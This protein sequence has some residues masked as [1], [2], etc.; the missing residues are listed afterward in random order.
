MAAAAAAPAARRPAPCAGGPP[1]PEHAACLRCTLNRPCLSC[2][3][4][5]RYV[6]Q[7]EGVDPQ[8][9]AVQV[10][11]QA[12]TAAQ[13]AQRESEALEASA[14]RHD[15]RNGGGSWLVR[16]GCRRLPVSCQA[17]HVPPL[18]FAS[19]APLPR[20]QAAM[21]SGDAA[22]VAATLRQ[23]RLD[24]LQVWTRH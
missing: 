6:D 18:G 15:R 13:R 21:E 19:D 4:H 17:Q 7:L 5:C 14:A 24:R 10:V 1:W 16:L 22:D 12:D 2:P 9:T 20:P 11:V 23:L 3:V 8:Q